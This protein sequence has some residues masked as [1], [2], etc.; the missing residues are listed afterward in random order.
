MLSLPL[1]SMEASSRRSTIDWLSLSLF[2]AFEPLCLCKSH[3]AMHEDGQRER[4]SFKGGSVQCWKCKKDNTAQHTTVSSIPASNLPL[5]PPPC[6][7]TI[8]SS[9]S[10][11]QSRSLCFSSQCLFDLFIHCLPVVVVSIGSSVLNFF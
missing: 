9:A 8:S 3:L 11:C 10:I 1:A 5:C 2:I 6:L 4:S 7:Q